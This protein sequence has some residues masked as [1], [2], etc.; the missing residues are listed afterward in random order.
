MRNDQWSL[1]NEWLNR[2]ADAF[3]RET[4]RLVQD[5]TIETEENCVVISGRSRSYYA[6]QLAIHCIQTFNH[7]HSLLPMTRLSLKVN[8]NSLELCLTH[9][10]NHVQVDQA[11]TQMSN[12]RCE[13]RFA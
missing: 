10:V 12:H 4:H 2:F 8:D 13:F 3:V 9:P 5:V 7:E 6:T 1:K 11:S